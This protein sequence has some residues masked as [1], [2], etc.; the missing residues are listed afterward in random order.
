MPALQIEGSRA[1]L[2]AKLREMAV[3][4]SHLGKPQRAE[5]SQAGAERLEA[6]ESTIKVGP[7]EYVVT[8]E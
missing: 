3:G 8:H 6:G 1:D 5:A 4:W 2:V 7:T